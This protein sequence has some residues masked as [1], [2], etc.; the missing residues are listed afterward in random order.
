MNDLTEIKKDATATFG[1]WVYLMSD[2]LLFAGLFSIYA[3]LA[4]NTFSGVGAK[5]IFSAPFALLET[6]ILLTSSFTTGI[7][8]LA[9]RAGKRGWVVL[10]LLV[11]V[12]LGASFVTLEFHEFWS[13]IAAGHG[14]QQSAFLS[15]YFTL[16]GTHGLHILIGLTWAIALIFVIARYGLTQPNMRKLALFSM[17]WH[18]LDIIWIFIFTIVYLLGLL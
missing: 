11:T 4:P 5:D 1:F 10:L 17:F 6:V 18:F 13:L 2:L 15:S 14:P 9:A 3:V 12:G 8:L 7:T 16:V